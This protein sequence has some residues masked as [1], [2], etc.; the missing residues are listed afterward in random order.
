MPET[1]RQTR[2]LT[3]SLTRRMIRWIDLNLLGVSA[4]L[5]FGGADSARGA[6]IVVLT[7]GLSPYQ[8]RFTDS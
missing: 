5:R 7:F 2:W 3:E 1:R 6:P 4:N 8:P